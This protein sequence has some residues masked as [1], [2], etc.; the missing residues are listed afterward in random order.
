MIIWRLQILPTSFS[1]IVVYDH[2]FIPSVHVKTRVNLLMKDFVLQY[3]F[4][5]RTR[6]ENGITF[7]ENYEGLKRID[8]T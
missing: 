5:L 2:N 7:S 4:F 1:V 8:N 3:R 6:C